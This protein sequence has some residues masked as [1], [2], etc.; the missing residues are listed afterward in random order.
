[1]RA[2]GCAGAG[3]V[4]VR[5]VG[6]G[7]ASRVIVVEDAAAAVSETRPRLTGA[8]KP[9]SVACLVAVSASSRFESR[10]PRGTRGVMAVGTGTGDEARARF[11]ERVGV[12]GASPK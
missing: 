3:A 12:E 2:G 11:R 4:V 10:V 1:M 9:L 6:G 7:D 8:K 5:A